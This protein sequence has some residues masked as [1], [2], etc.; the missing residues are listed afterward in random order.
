M[1]SWT[2]GVQDI[3][4]YPTPIINTQY[5][6]KH[7]TKL[8]YP[9][10]TSYKHLIVQAYLYHNLPKKHAKHTFSLNLPTTV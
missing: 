2:K 5:H 4:Y 6:A 10:E 1:P 8:H 3:F 7:H 9:M